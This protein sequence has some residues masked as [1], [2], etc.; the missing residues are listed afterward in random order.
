[1][2]LQY[3]S[4]SMSC[5]LQKKSLPLGLYSS[6]MATGQAINTLC[7]LCISVQSLHLYAVSAS[8]FNLCIFVQSLH[9]YASS[10]SLCNLCLSVP[11]L[12]YCAIS[13]SL[14]TLP[15][16]LSCLCL[17]ALFQLCPHHV[18][19]QGTPS[20]FIASNSA[21]RAQVSWHPLSDSANIPITDSTSASHQ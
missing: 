19:S 4:S 1:M 8:L 18:L 16:H 2:L 12:H 6:S 21:L 5:P 11:S 9:P 10:A 3:T 17:H 14:C 13:A 15:L 20:Q 7:H